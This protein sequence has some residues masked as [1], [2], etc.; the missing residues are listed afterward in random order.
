MLYH[1]TACEAAD[2]NLIELLD[3]S[4]R[5]LTWLL[6]NSKKIKTVEKADVKKMISKTDE[7]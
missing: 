3:Y 1:R 7:E 4:Y 6:G 5:K 2:S